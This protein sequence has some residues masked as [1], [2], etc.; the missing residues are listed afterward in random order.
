GIPYID[1]DVANDPEAR[2]ELTGKYGR[3]ATPTMV[4]GG[5]VFVGFQDN[6]KAIEQALRGEG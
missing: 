3:M 1:K 2:K 4:I 5:K 6:R